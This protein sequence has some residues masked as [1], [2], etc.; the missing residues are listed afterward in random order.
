MDEHEKDSSEK[1]QEPPTEPQV[2]V[3]P[4]LAAAREETA[5]PKQNLF[6][7]KATW[8]DELKQLNETLQ[9]AEEAIRHQAD[10]IAEKK[11]EA[12]GKSP[13][14]EGEDTFEF[15]LK[16]M[17]RELL[18]KQVKRYKEALENE[19]NYVEELKKEKMDV[20]E[21]VMQLK[22]VLGEKD[23]EISTL[24]SGKEALD[25]YVAELA[26][27]M[28]KE[29]TQV[30]FPPHLHSVRCELTQI[31]TKDGVDEGLFQGGEQAAK[32]HGRYNSPHA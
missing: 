20:E 23:L 11:A 12:K 5:Q 27:E 28:E 19:R 13:P 31:V 14:T 32:R 8:E 7:L 26:E 24:Q 22:L 1:Q 15:R 30:L 2:L 9:S 29:T 6:Q 16:V 25:L 3:Q 18:E 4:S 10:R 17:P 21:E